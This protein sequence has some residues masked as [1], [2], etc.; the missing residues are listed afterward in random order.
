MSIAKHEARMRDV[1][2]ILCRKLGYG[3]T[4]PALHHPRSGT[5]GGRKASDWLVTPL[6]QPHHQGDDGLH[7]MGSKAFVRHYGHTE[8][9][10]LESALAIAYEGASIPD[11]VAAAIAKQWPR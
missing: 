5:G 3:V 10:L 2:C 8:R 11:K 9:E 7:G 6:C 4:P 1:G